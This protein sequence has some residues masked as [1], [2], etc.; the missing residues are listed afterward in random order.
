VRPQIYILTI[1]LWITFSCGNN[2][3]KTNE[4]SETVSETLST[5]DY[6]IINSTFPHLV[7]SP[8]PGTTRE[9]SYD[10]FN[11]K[12]R[13]IPEEYFRNVFFT[14]A[15]V[16]LVDTTVFYIRPNE[17]LIIEDTTIQKL[18]NSLFT[19]EQTELIV[20]TDSITNTGL[21]KIKPVPKEQNIKMEIGE[22]RITYSKIIYNV[23]QTKA[24]FYFQND[25]SGLCGFGKFIVVEKVKEI[26]TITKEYNDWVS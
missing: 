2:S 13:N 6:K 7:I 8:P 25:C 19:D 12:N 15:L 1:F 23:D 21:W 26:W 5:E 18:Y 20:Q 10:N 14:N 3:A 22:R 16:P 17:S 11:P 4:L 9:F 24:I